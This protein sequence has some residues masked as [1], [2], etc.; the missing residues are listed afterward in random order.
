MSAS[1]AD[2]AFAAAV[3]AKLAAARQRR[4]DKSRAKWRARV[5]AVFF[6]CRGEEQYEDY[7]F[8]QSQWGQ[9]AKPHL[10]QMIPHAVHP[11]QTGSSC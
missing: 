10:G 8:T 1:P 5:A 7:D 9:K 11:P 4:K 6:F 3:I 2:A